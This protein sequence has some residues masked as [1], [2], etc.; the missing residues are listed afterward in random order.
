MFLFCRLGT[1]EALLVWGWR[2]CVPQ[3]SP[4]SGAQVPAHLRHLPPT[5]SGWEEDMCGWGPGNSLWGVGTWMWVLHCCS[6]QE[7]KEKNVA[8]EPADKTKCHLR[9]LLPT[10]WGPSSRPSAPCSPA[11]SLRDT[12]LPGLT[13]PAGSPGTATSCSHT[14]LRTQ[15]FK[16][17]LHPSQ[18]LRGPIPP[19]PGISSLLREV[20]IICVAGGP[21]RGLRSPETPLYSRPREPGA[22]PAAPGTC[23]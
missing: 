5:L 18:A 20:G 14:P 9:L 10:P 12:T 4:E 15:A 23:R 21:G 2:Y 8:I 17:A 16:L 22:S 11:V 7:T 1:Q 19:G 6:W 13:F 3:Q